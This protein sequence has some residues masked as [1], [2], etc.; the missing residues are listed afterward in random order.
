MMKSFYFRLTFSIIH[1]WSFDFPTGVWTFPFW[2]FKYPHDM[3]EFGKKRISNDIFHFFCVTLHIRSFDFPTIPISY[4]IP[5]QSYKYLVLRSKLHLSK[6]KLQNNIYQTFFPFL[7]LIFPSFCVTLHLGPPW[8]YP[9]LRP[10]TLLHFRERNIWPFD[11]NCIHL[12]QLNKMVLRSSLLLCLTFHSC[13]M[14]FPT[15]PISYFR[16]RIFAPSIKT[17]YII[18]NCRRTKYYIRCIDSYL[19]LGPSIFPSFLPYFAHWSF[20]FPT[21]PSITFQR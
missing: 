5:F 16:I 17:T 2:H 11:K 21:I 12:K 1:I 7:P 13:S 6:D 20:D 19:T 10:H 9:P 8:T 15:I 3:R 4:I 14:D 18:G